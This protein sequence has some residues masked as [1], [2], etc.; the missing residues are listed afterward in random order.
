MIIS[1]GFAKLK[2]EI[3]FAK[4]KMKMGNKVTFDYSKAANVVREE[5]VAAMKKMTE[6]AKEVLVSKSGLGNDFLA[7]STFL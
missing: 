6:T 5:E 4:E 7:G 3:I 1:K 2:E